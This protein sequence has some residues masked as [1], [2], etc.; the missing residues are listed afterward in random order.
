MQQEDLHKANL[1]Q[2]VYRGGSIGTGLQPI[3]K[4]GKMSS[5][6]LRKEINNRMNVTLN[7]A[8]H[9][10][11]GKSNMINPY[12]NITTGKPKQMPSTVMNS[13]EKLNV[14]YQQPPVTAQDTR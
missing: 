12:D 13:R 1:S 3:A 5:S 2:V 11:L 14:G 10:N 4:P 7:P 9:F 6:M 8:K